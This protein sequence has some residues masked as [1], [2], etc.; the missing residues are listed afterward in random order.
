M[1]KQITEQSIF[2]EQSKEN[3]QLLLFSKSTPYFF[4]SKR[5]IKRYYKIFNYELIWIDENGIKDIALKLLSSIRNDPV[6]K[7]YANKAFKLNQ[8]VS[9]LTSLDK[10]DD[11][12]LQSMTKIDF[13]LT[14]MYDRY[15]KYLANGF[16][17]WKQFKEQRKEL[18]LKEE[19]TSSWEK[20][21]S[22]KN[23]KKLLLEAITNNDLQIAFKAVNYTYPKAE[24]LSNSIIKF[25]EIL[26]NGGYTKIPKFKVLKEGSISPVINILRKRLLESEDL[27]SNVCILNE[28]EDTNETIITEGSATIE[29]DCFNNFDENVQKAVISFQESHGLK[30]DGVVG[31]ITRK[32]LNIPI[33]EKIRKMRLNL[34]RMR[35]MPRTLGEKY[36]LVN[37][38][39]YKLRLYD[40]DEVALDMKIVVGDKE[41]PTAIFSNKMSFI[42]LNPY[43]R[44]PQ[45]IVKKEIVPKILKDISYLDNKGINLHQNW[46]HNSAQYKVRNI[47][48]TIY[49]RNIANK[50]AVLPI[51]FIQVPSDTNP[52]G[53]M[54]FMFP[55]RYSIYIHDTPA[56]QHFNYDMRAYSHGCI[57][58]EDSKRLLEVIAQKDA[59]IDY[60]EANIILEDIDKK[61][62][63]LESKIPVH[64]VYLTSWI[65]QNGKLQFRDDIYNHDLIQEE[66][67]FD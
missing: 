32:Y 65:D 10:S 42:V 30:A 47:N 33:E 48:W 51:R 9:E 61:D 2:K 57:R 1:G 37:I 27:I 31:K 53:R 25:E 29:N 64:M 24:E 6:L 12:Y 15:R 56:K 20:Y 7:P 66:I 50:E 39:E 44:I 16:I 38:P 23:R 18:D 60:E 67:L 28:N 58:V 13:M 34:E 62:L 5:T 19:I 8:I 40:K 17:N 43:W 22:N 52:L 45:S 14:G 35:W 36:L 11:K 26:V 54:K 41:H 63:N 55:N 3:I 59:N 4:L 21:N 49:S 46:D